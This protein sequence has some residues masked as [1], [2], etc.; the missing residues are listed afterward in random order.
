MDGHGHIVDVVDLDGQTIHGKTPL[1]YNI[2]DR[3]LKMT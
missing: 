3:D 2:D 1:L